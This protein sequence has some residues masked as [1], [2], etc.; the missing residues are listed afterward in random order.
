MDKGLQMKPEK[1][2]K[3]EEGTRMGIERIGGGYVKVAVSREDLEESISGP[4]QLKPILQ[5]IVIK[6]NGSNRRQ[7][8]VDSAQI[9]Q[10]FDTAITAMTILLSGFG[11]CGEGGK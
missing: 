5:A 2:I 3:R 11:D 1:D 6:S 9:K 4:S 10:H 8:A 7:A